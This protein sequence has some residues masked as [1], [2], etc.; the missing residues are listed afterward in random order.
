[1]QFQVQ[2]VKKDYQTET[3]GQRKFQT[4]FSEIAT[5]LRLSYDQVA[6][7]LEFCNQAKARKDILEIIGY[8]N[9]TDNYR[10]YIL[11]LIENDLLQFTLPNTPKSSKQK[12]QITDKGLAF[13]SLIEENNHR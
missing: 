1:M 8:K 6:K 5:K 2:F 9:H 3:D 10:K 13:M 7:V 12:Y 4:L 11:P